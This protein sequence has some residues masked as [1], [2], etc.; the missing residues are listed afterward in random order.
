MQLRQTLSPYTT[1]GCD[2]LLGIAESALVLLGI[3]I[4]SGKLGAGTGLGE[5]GAGIQT[6]VAAP[7]TGTGTGLLSFATGLRAVFETFGDLGRGLST[8]FESIPD[9]GPVL[10]GPWIPGIVDPSPPPGEVPPGHPGVFPMIVTSGG[11]N[12]TLLPGG[13]GLVPQTRTRPSVGI[14][15]PRPRIPYG[16]DQPVRML[17]PGGSTEMR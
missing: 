5:L 17:G 1:N 15:R 16:G 2:A 14:A 7:L 4:L 3:G 13:G 12:Q 11:S 6:L 8:L 10:P 9:L